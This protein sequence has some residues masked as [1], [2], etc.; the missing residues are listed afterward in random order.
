MLSQAAGGCFWVRLQVYD[1][2]QVRGYPCNCNWPEHCD[3]QQGSLPPTRM[4]TKAPATAS[5]HA[6]SQPQQL[7]PHAQQSAPTN[8]DHHDG[9]SGHSDQEANG[10]FQ[11]STAHTATR[12]EST[13]WQS[14]ACPEQTPHNRRLQGQD[15][16]SAEGRATRIDT[17]AQQSLDQ[18][19]PNHHQEEQ[20]GLSGE[21]D[22]QRLEQE[23]VHDVYNAIAP[24]FS[25]TRFA[26]WP[27]VRL[28]Q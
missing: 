24:H 22:L 8:S 7:Y 19:L 1:G 10:L 11:H 17:P 20:R 4:A 9:A 21:A 14:T 12:L 18:L 23:F 13:D 16:V 3:S 15:E 2:L 26:I 27:K 25:S 28:A 6:C 5:T